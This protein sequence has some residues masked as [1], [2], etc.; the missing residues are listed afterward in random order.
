MLGLNMW[1]LYLNIQNMEAEADCWGGLLDSRALFW[2]PSGPAP[3]AKHS[4]SCVSRKEHWAGAKRALTC[5]ALPFHGER[6]QIWRW[7]T[8][9][10]HREL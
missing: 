5:R 2:V 4:E 8:Q 10:P 3:E 7:R 9:S 1:N 6:T